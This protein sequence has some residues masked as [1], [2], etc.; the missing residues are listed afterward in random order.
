MTIPV[1][2]PFELTRDDLMSLYKAKYY[3]EGEP[4][5]SPRMRLSFDY[6]T[7]DDYYEALVSRLVT[8]GCEWADIGC[9]RDVFPRFS[10]LARDLCSRASFVYGIDP[11]DNVLENPYINDRF[12]GVGDDCGT[13]RRFDV[14][15]MRM[16][17]EHIVD[18]DRAIKKV[19]ELLKPGGITVIYTPYKW[20]PMSVVASLLPFSLHHPLKRLIWDAEARDTFP[21]A[22]NLNTRYDL[23]RHTSNHGLEE[24]SFQMLDDCRVLTRYHWLNYGELTLQRLLRSMNVGYPERCI[25]A[26]YEKKR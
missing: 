5:Q 19:A 23:A 12:H 24:R 15:T 6:F 20:A 17:A 16:V 11:D 7:P 14:L 4:G 9:G 2:N 18:A 3:R 25:L 22:Y 13:E 10:E 8:P 21:T 26:V 1:R